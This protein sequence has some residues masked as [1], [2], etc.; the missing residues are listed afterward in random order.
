MAYVTKSVLVG[1][2]QKSASG[3]LGVRGA[4]KKSIA[5]VGN[6][7]GARDLCGAACGGGGAGIVAAQGPFFGYFFWPCK[8]SDPPEA[9]K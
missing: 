2:A 1:G 9:F 4:G 7:E 3:Y 6:W 8:K 5:W